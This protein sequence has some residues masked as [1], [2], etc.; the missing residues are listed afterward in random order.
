MTEPPLDDESPPEPQRPLTPA[1]R[2]GATP[3]DPERFRLNAGMPVGQ[4]QR[5][6]LGRPPGEY[7]EEVVE[8][9]VRRRR[10][11]DADAVGPLPL[12]AD[13]ADVEL[14]D[15]VADSVGIGR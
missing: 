3:L 1:E 7:P 8:P 6:L 14:L 10:K 5:E 11:L 15:A 13:R 12:H 9:V 2:A 4:R